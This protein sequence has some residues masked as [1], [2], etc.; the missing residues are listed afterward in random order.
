[1]NSRLIP[2]LKTLH[3]TLDFKV[4]YGVH[5]VTCTLPRLYQI[6]V[7][8]KIYWGDPRE[9]ICEA[10]EHIPLSSLV[11]GNRS[12]GGHKRMIMGCLIVFS[13]RIATVEGHRT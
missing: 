6:T 11:I 5:K 1:M 7:V 4:K 12:L 13:A 2:S 3:S 10:V 9:K 8:M